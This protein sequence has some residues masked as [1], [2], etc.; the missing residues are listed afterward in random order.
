ME[1]ETAI[2]QTTEAYADLSRDKVGALMVFER[3]NLLDDV[4]KTGHGS[5]LRAYPASC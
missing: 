2:T 5:G 1:I 4:I 3:K